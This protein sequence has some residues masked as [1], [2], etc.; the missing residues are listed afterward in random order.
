VRYCHYLL[1]TCTAVLL[2]PGVSRSETEGKD[3]TPAVR[4]LWTRPSSDGRNHEILS[5]AKAP[6][7]KATVLYVVEGVSDRLVARSEDKADGEFVL[8]KLDSS[9][10]VLHREF[11]GKM[12]PGGKRPLPRVSIVTLDAAQQ[13]A[14]LV[15]IFDGQFVWSLRRVDDSAKIVTTEE[16]VNQAS[17]FLSAVLL[18]DGKAVLL[19]GQF[20]FGG[21]VWKIDL[22]GEALWKQTYLSKTDMSKTD[23][24]EKVAA[25]FSGIALTDD[26]GGFIAAGDFGKINKFGVGQRSVWL[27]RCDEA[28]KVVSETTFP[29]RLPTISPLGK[30][31]FVVLYDAGTEMQVDSRVRAVDIDLTEQWENKVQF[32]A[33]WSDRPAMSAIPSGRGFV[34]AGTNM[35]KDGK[36]VRFECRFLQY[37][38]QGRVVSLASIPVAEETFVHARIACE[39]D[40]AYVAAQ[41]RG[42]NAWNVQE[43]S[44]FEIPLQ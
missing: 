10:H 9:G 31:R 6:S 27:V 26:Q 21:N 20:G 43:A 37:D 35:S 29:G 22:D 39:E 33:L 5:I 40:R 18:P 17:A 41:T 36:S 15:G 8:W 23:I 16:L 12:P 19:A 25:K 34:L 38:A 42:M 13:G 1:L 7:G 28:G 30:G 11:L 32:N 2:L 14:I 4:S 3:V 44:I 24:A